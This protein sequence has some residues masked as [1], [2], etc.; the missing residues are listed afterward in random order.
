MK[1]EIS[2]KF[3]LNPDDLH[4]P[5]VLIGW[6][7]IALVAQLAITSIK[8]SIGAKMFL[9]IECFDF[10]PKSKVEKGK[11]EL[12][13]ARV[14]YKSRKSENKPDL[15]ILTASDQPLTSAGVFEFSQVFCEE[16][17]KLTKSK[18]KMYILRNIWCDRDG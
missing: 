15:F 3:D 16:M 9:E 18:I 13:S 10:P 8:D 1:I 6:P 17:D 4:D 5:I 14:Y 7:G 12:P 11:M 2:R